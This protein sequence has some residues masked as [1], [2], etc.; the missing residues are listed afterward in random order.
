MRGRERRP[1]AHG[2]SRPRANRMRSAAIEASRSLISRRAVRTDCPG[3]E[4]IEGL[5]TISALPV[6]AD[7]RASLA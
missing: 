5:P 2:V 1:H 3:L 7:W 6:F 4:T